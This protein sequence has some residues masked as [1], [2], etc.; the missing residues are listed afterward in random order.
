MALNPSHTQIKY[1]IKK[2]QK[3]A[4]A[5]KSLITHLYELKLGR[6]KKEKNLIDKFIIDVK[7]YLGE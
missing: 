7:F 3:P 4:S 6:S 1:P 5:R 2:S